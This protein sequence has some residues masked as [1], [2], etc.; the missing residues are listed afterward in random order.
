MFADSWEKPALCVRR[1]HRFR[2]LLCIVPT[3]ASIQK[4]HNSK[5]SHS[6]CVISV[7]WDVCLTIWFTSIFHLRNRTLQRDGSLSVSLHQFLLAFLCRVSERFSVKPSLN[8]QKN[9]FRPTLLT[10][11]LQHNAGLMV[12]FCSRWLCI[13]LLTPGH[14]LD[15]RRGPAQTKST[16]E[17]SGLTFFW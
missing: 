15:W 4:H 2:Q 8:N 12:V 1:C 3:G 9:T 16:R 10:N 7:R 14:I 5:R 13:L 6:P 11:K 17:S